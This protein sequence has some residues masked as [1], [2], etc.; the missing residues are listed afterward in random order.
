MMPTLT[1]PVTTFT[2]TLS[3]ERNGATAKHLEDFLRREIT[4]SMHRAQFT[5]PAGSKMLNLKIASKDG[6]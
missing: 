4:K 6:K 3:I 1:Q 5:S 2:I